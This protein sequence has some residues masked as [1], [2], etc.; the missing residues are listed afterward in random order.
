M[1]RKQTK[2]SLEDGNIMEGFIDYEKDTEVEILK[3]R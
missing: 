1:V 2:T 3:Y